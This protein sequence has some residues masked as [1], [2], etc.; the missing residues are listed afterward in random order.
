MARRAGDVAPDQ[1]TRWW[2]MVGADV[3]GGPRPRGVPVASPLASPWTRRAGVV[4]P[5]QAVQSRKR[6]FRLI[7]SRTIRRVWIFMHDVSERELDDALLP[8]KEIRK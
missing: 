7:L 1:V 8:D 4:A 5:C 2:G 6:P 3:H